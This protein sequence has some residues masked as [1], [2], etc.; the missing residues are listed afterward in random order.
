MHSNTYRTIHFSNPVQTVV[1]LSKF[2]KI[3]HIGHLYRHSKS[4]VVFNVIFMTLIQ[5]RQFISY[6]HNY[7]L[8]HYW[9]NVIVKTFKLKRLKSKLIKM[10]SNC[11]DYYFVRRNLWKTFVF[12]MSSCVINDIKR[13]H[14]IDSEFCK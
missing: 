13:Y 4:T 5:F 11:C 3:G 1:W 8:R 10:T 2:V 7:I 9:L 12:S 6:D 14:Q